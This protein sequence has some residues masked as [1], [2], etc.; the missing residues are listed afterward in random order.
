MAEVAVWQ[1]VFL[2]TLDA[3]RLHADVDEV[4]VEVLG[5][6]VRDRAAVETARVHLLDMCSD[7][8]HHADVSLAVAYLGAALR[9]GDVAGTWRRTAPSLDPW[10]VAQHRQAVE[11]AVPM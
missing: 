1:S 6:A 3:A 11:R 7:A 10:V 9:R 5:L 4:A 2:H 8:R